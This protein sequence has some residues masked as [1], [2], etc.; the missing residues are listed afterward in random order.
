[1]SKPSVSFTYLKKKKKVKIG[2]FLVVFSSHFSLS[3]SPPILCL[4][5]I[6]VSF[7]IRLLCAIFFSHLLGH[8][9]FPIVCI[10]GQKGA[11]SSIPESTL[12]GLGSVYMSLWT[13]WYV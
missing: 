7:P 12:L 11:H 5:A 6:P 3:L 13:V 1:M 10:S 2:K 4:D 8:P 9:S